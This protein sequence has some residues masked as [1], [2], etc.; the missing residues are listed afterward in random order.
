MRFTLA[1]DYPVAFPDTQPLA[2]TAP[3]RTATNM[4]VNVAATGRLRG[5]LRV[6]STVI[7][8][9]IDPISNY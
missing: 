2:I 7:S 4:N 8:K 3:K 6:L 9:V 5:S 1:I